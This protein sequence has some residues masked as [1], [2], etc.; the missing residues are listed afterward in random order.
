MVTESAKA[1][2]ALIGAIASAL[3]G[4]FTAETVVG[5][6][7]TVV[8]VIATAVATFAVPNADPEAEWDPDRD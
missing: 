5:Q 1:W 8:V 2:V 4:V 6:V 3:L 7:L